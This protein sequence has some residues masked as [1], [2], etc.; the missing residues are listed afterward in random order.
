MDPP[1]LNLIRLGSDWIVTNGELADDGSIRF[2]DEDPAEET[3]G[4]NGAPPDSLPPSQSA[5]PPSES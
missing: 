2:P 5:V 4:A 1:P 3:F